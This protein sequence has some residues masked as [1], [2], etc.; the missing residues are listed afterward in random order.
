MNRCA[1]FFLVVLALAS[2]AANCEQC[3]QTSNP[4]KGNLDRAADAV[5]VTDDDGHTLAVVANPELEH[6]RIFD[7]TTEAFLLAPNAFFPQSVPV[8]AD[9]RRL[10]VADGDNRFVFAL[11]SASD[12]VFVVAA[13]AGTFALHGEPLATGRAPGDL[14]AVVGDD[15][16]LELWVTLPDESAVQ[17]LGL[18]G[19]ELARLPIDVPSAVLDTRAARPNDI[20]VDP[21]GESVVVADATLPFVHVFSRATRQLA[22]SLD[23][24][25]PLGSLSVGVIDIGDG[26][27]P[28]VLALR[29]DAPIAVAI[30]LFRAVP[31]DR[32]AVLGSVELP[33]IPLVAYVPDHRG[34][35][36]LPP[37]VCCREL[38]SD[39]VDA[40]QATDAWAAVAS[41]DGKITYLQVLAVE[42]LLR[43]FDNDL[44]GPALGE[45]LSEAWS[46]APGDEDKEPTAGLTLTSDFGD[47][48][49]V[50]L[51]DADEQLRL[52]WQG[53]PP[54]L[55]G[56]RGTWDGVSAFSASGADLQARGAAIGDLAI[57]A[58]DD[59]PAG[60]SDSVAGVI[61]T[62][63]AGVVDI[64]L[65]NESDQPCLVAGSSLRVSVAPA[66]AFA[67]FDRDGDFLGRLQLAGQLDV[68]GALLTV[69]PSANGSPTERGSALF[70]PL[71]P[72]L[73]PIDLD[74]SDTGSFATSDPGG[75]GQGALLPVALIGGEMLIPGVEVGTQVAARRMVVATGANNGFGTNSLFAC[76]EGETIAGLCEEFR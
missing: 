58:I 43:I 49:F 24:G 47:P 19:V 28:V 59:A 15:G 30:R 48:P 73:A 76:D 27:A 38:S 72:H 62:V 2:V 17:V 34:G 36:A 7:L 44:D 70:V 52:I 25:G 56:V 67:V 60:C 5:L 20:V 8:G 12:Q 71:N 63:A 65:N 66:A 55:D 33:G 1:P 57:I 69:A 6:L 40:G 9:T 61:A 50:P 51:L 13:A 31:E 68:G 10:A 3:S 42:G 22:R 26:L 75:F 16:A 4:R 35:G 21:L 46:P 64:S 39:A 32:Y 23:V 29:R 41:A 74:L 53:S 18:D 14:A 45:P 54:G 11:D 37:T